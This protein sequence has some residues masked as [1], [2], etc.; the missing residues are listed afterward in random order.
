MK[1]KEILLCAENAAFDKKDLLK[2]RNYRWSDGTGT[3]PKCWWSIISNEQLPNEKAWLDDQIYCLLGAS[4]SLRKI[5]ITAF[6]RYSFR[7]ERIE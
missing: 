2:S 5:E 6:K 7:A 4:D 3:L 1:A